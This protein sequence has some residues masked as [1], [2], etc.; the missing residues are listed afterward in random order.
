VLEHLPSKGEALSSNPTTSKNKKEE[1]KKEN[2]AGTIFKNTESPEKEEL[3]L[4]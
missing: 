2:M 4:S 3:L 1:R